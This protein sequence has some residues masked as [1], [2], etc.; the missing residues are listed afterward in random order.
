MIHEILH[1]LGFVPANAPRQTLTGHVPEPNDLMYAGSAPW[2]LPNLVLDVGHNDYYGEN[3]P[4]GVPNLRDSPF[5]LS[6]TGATLERPPVAAESLR[7]P[8]WLTRAGRNERGRLY[9]FLH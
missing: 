9:S 7:A 5:L 3:V 2:A 1:T 4:A 8:E 6:A